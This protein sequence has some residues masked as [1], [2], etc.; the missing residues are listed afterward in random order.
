MSWLGVVLVFLAPASL[1]WSFMPV[2][3][4]AF[5]AAGSYVSGWPATGWSPADG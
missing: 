3:I 1:W 2:R 4:M 5:A